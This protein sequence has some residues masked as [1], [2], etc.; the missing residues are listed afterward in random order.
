M[1]CFSIDSEQIEQF[2]ELGYCVIDVATPE[3]NIDQIARWTREEFSDCRMGRR[4]DAWKYMPQVRDLAYDM[5]VTAA[6]NELYGGRKAIPFQTLNFCVGTQQALHSDTIHFNS[7]PA[8]GMCGVWVA[9]E[10]VHPDSGPLMIVPGSH[11]WN[12]ETMQSVGVAPSEV[13]YRYYEY[14]ILGLVERSGVKQEPV[15]IKKGQALIWSANLIHGGSAIKNTE[16]TRISQVT[17]YFISGADFYY[18]P[19]LSDLSTG[20]IQKRDLNA[21]AVR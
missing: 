1:G 15:I 17:H 21:L 18:T 2:D 9:M 10:D 13:N 12:E 8:G 20:Q 5:H 19:M 4:Q 6:L 11:K 7:Y 14:H 3:W 16:L